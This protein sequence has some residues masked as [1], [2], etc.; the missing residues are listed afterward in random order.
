MRQRHRRR[1]RQRAHE[2]GQIV[3]DRP[4]IG[5]LFEERDEL[6]DDAVVEVVHHLADLRV[7]IAGH[8]A[9]RQHRIVVGVHRGGTADHPLRERRRRLAG[10]A[11]REI[12]GQLSSRSLASARITASTAYLESK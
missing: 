9:R 1:R 6:V 11:R 4:R 3:G 10:L 7:G 8:R 12:V 2:G 5:V